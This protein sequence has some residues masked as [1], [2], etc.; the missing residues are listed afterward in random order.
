MHSLQKQFQ[1][2]LE[3]AD[4]IKENDAV[5]LAVSGGV[6]SMVMLDLFKYTSI[7]I[8]VAHCNF[9]LRGQ[10]S[11]KDMDLVRDYCA[12][13]KI[14]FYFREISIESNSIQ[15]E[16]REKRY[17]WFAELLHEKSYQ[18]LATAHHLDDSV[19]TVLINLARGTGVTGLTGIDH[20]G[21]V[22]RPLL[23]ATKDQLYTY[24]KETGLLWREDASNQKLDY[25]R[26]VIRA[27]IL[28]VLNELNPGF[29]RSFE[30]TSERLK[31]TNTFLESQIKQHTNEY[32]E[33]E[34]GKLTID[35]VQDETNL[36]ILDG[37]LKRFGF[38]YFT[39]KEIFKALKQPGKRFTSD[40]YQVV[41]D[42]QCI[43]I[44]PIMVQHQNEL[45]IGGEGVF[46]WQQ[47]TFDVEYLHEIKVTDE[48]NMAY[49]DLEKITFPLTIRAWQKGDRFVPLGMK[50]KKLVSDLLIDEKLPSALKHKVAVVISGNDICWVVNHRISD[51]F[52]I[53]PSTKRVVRI[54]FSEKNDQYVGRK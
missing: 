30:R 50:G 8:G 48:K 42:R 26:N 11:D 5:L 46:D 19:E 6:D 21:N 12:K 23:F 29:L 39:C 44:K 41:I 7:P 16:A 35:W 13:H 3:E 51:R 27:K 32:F 34:S 33:E 2:Y 18:K 47:G 17:H 53:R 25:K 9:K 40:N 15:T 54:Q 52:K 49:L 36:I 45:V 24:A 22:I 14:D 31:L 43:F 1:E 4:L 38:N 20:M 28:P 37:I 10:E